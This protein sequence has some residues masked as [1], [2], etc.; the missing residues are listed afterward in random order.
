MKGRKYVKC[1][2]A[3]RTIMVSTNVAAPN[4]LANNFVPAAFVRT[5][6]V[7]TSF[8]DVFCSKKLVLKTIALMSL[9]LTIFVLLAYVQ[10]IDVRDT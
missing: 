2:N 3:V 4:S 7:L 6:I 9:F 8:S 5:K 1:P 10:V